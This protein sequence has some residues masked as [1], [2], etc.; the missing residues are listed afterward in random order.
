MKK[1]TLQKFKEM[2]YT[3]IAIG[4]S[5]NDID[6][7]KDYESS[8]KLNE[9]EQVKNDEIYMKV[10]VETKELDDAIKKLQEVKKL[11]EENIGNVEEKSE[12]ENTEKEKQDKEQ[13]LKIDNLN[14]KLIN[15]GELRAEIEEENSNLKTKKEALE[16]QIENL[17]EQ[18]KEM[19]TKLNKPTAGKNLTNQEKEEP[20]GVQALKY[21][22]KNARRI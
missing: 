3:S 5:Y 2:N 20:V 17:N 1:I 14:A 15:C 18:I 12:E 13:S 8:K 7:L 9:A 11:T 19:E 4:D 22:T 10:K 6:M 16:T 21:L